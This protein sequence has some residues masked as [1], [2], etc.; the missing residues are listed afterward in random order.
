MIWAP[1]LWILH[2]K[3]LSRISCCCLPDLFRSIEFDHSHSPLAWTAIGIL[4]TEYFSDLFRI[5]CVESEQ[6]LQPI[7]LLVCHRIDCFELVTIWFS[8]SNDDDVFSRRPAYEP[9][10]NYRNKSD[11]RDRSDVPTDATAVPPVLRLQ[12]YLSNISS[13][14]LGIVIIYIIK[15]TRCLQMY[16]AIQSSNGYRIDLYDKWIQERGHPKGRVGFHSL[17]MFFLVSSFTR[18]LFPVLPRRIW[19]LF[20]PSSIL[21]VQ[22]FRV[23][24]SFIT[25]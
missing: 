25:I 12:K 19:M 10:Y 24:L 7:Q 23:L 17:G 6:Q 5:N 4:W 1:I 9:V 11:R 18:W 21:S 16:A 13:R 8:C 15:N 2:N 3:V 14:S 20:V 22:F